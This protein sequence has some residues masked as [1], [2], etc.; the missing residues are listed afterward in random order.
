MSD[1]AAGLLLLRAL[2]HQPNL[3]KGMPVMSTRSRTHSAQS[4]PRP[5]LGGRLHEMA[6]TGQ[7]TT[8]MAPESRAHAGHVIDPLKVGPVG[9]SSSSD[10]AGEW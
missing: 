3:L 2:E 9:S 8:P 5:P 4:S 7:G 1:L 10:T 6:I